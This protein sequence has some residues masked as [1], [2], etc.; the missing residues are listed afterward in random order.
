MATTSQTF[1]QAVAD[2]SQPTSRVWLWTGR[3]ITGLV[4]AFMLFDTAMHLLKPAPVVDAFKQLGLPI[5]LSVP[6]GIIS[7]ICVA[8]YAL[9]A[10]NVLGAILLTGYLGGAVATN[11]WVRHPLFET[12]FPVLVGVFVWAGVYLRDERLRVLLPWKSSM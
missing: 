4:I 10:T 2:Q 5:S 11:M 8:F 7:L 6:L 9:P 12:I 3:T 1:I